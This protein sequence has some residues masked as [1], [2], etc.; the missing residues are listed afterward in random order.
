MCDREEEGVHVLEEGLALIE[1]EGYRR[2]RPKHRLLFLSAMLVGQVGQC[3]LD[4]KGKRVEAPR[5][6]VREGLKFK[7]KDCDD[8]STILALLSRFRAMGAEGGAPDR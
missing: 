2:P 4:R 1:S 7:N 5:V 6:I 3:V 8:V